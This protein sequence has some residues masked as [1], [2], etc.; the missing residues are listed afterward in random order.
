MA[1]TAPLRAPISANLHPIPTITPWPQARGLPGRLLA[2]LLS[3]LLT[4]PLGLSPMSAQAQEYPPLAEPVAAQPELEQAVADG[5][6]DAEAWIGGPA[7]FVAGCLLTWV[8][9]LVAYVVEPEPPP[10]RLIGKS[11]DYVEVYAQSFR[12][13]G[14][15][16]QTRMAALGCLTNVAL[17]L[18]FVATFLHGDQ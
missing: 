13:A 4:L 12:K 10:A 16:A 3:A 14:A 5:E 15:I 9:V 2:L 11:S 8:G 7:W 6:H 18:A 17:S 1:P